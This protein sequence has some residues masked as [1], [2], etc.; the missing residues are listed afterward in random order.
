MVGE[1]VR[2]SLREEVEHEVGGIHTNEEVRF[3]EMQQSSG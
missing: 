1:V 2:K 3:A